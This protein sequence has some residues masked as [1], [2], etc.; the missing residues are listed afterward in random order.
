VTAPA[1]LEAAD[2]TSSIS[3]VDV[4]TQYWRRA[5]DIRREWLGHGLSTAPADRAITEQTLTGIYARLGRA[6]P[7]FVWVDSPRAALPHLA[8][9]PTHDDLCSWIAGRRPPG[10][11]P[12]ASDLVAALSHLRGAL[13]SWLSH[14]DLNP[15]RP[16]KRR[17]GKPWPKLP[18]LEGIAAGLPL[19]EVLRQGVRET[20]ATSLADG[21][22]LPVRAALGALAGPRPLPVCWYGQHDAAWIAYYDV[23]RRLG[24][25]WYPAVD[26]EHLA[27]WAALARSGGWWWPG[28]EVCVVVERPAVVRTGPLIRYRDGWRPL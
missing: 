8:G 27:D 19:R 21:C 17:D 12:L 16:G 28:E 11:P 24:L 9:L 1:R 5:D 6:R 13:D 25:A 4:A 14:P 22:Y 18:P 20:L 2:A 23:M 10:R 26:S 7:R 3:P 15:A